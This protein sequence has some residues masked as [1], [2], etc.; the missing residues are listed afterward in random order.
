[1][2]A[3]DAIRKMANV[4]DREAKTEADSNLRSK[5]V[6]EKSVRSELNKAVPP[7][8]AVVDSKPALATA[9]APAKP[10]A[11][12]PSQPELPAAAAPGSCSW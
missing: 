3:N 10:A 4:K 7:I 2:A 9:P 11:A 6:G 5:K 8:G 1:M 12:I